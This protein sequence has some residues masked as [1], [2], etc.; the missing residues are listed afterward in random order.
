MSALV[1]YV[2]LVTYIYVADQAGVPWLTW[3]QSLAPEEWFWP[4]FFVRPKNIIL[5]KRRENSM[6]QKL[7]EMIQITVWLYTDDFFCW[8]YKNKNGPQNLSLQN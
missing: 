6:K 8:F 7:S 4:L 2:Y 3:S 1:N 5:I